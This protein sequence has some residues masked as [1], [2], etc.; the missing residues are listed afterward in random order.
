MLDADD[1]ASIIA[2][3]RLFRVAKAGERPIVFWIGAG[4][5][6]WLGY[7]SWKD[8]ALQVRRAF[9]EDVPGFNDAYAMRLIDKQEFP[10]L[11]QLCKD[12][13]APNYRK[14]IVETFAPR[15]ATPTYN[16]FL[17]LL[18][19]ITPSF[20]LTTNVDECLEKSFPH[21]QTL[22]RSDVTRC[23]DLLNRE[24]PFVAKLHGSIS[25]VQSTVFTTS[26]YSDIIADR[27]YLGCLKHIFTACTVVFLGY[28]V[29]DGYII[30]MLRDNA[31]EMDL[32]GPG[33]HFAVTNQEVPVSSLQ[34][35]KYSPKFRADHTAALSI[36]VHVD[37]SVEERRARPIAITESPESALDVAEETRTPGA[38]PLGKTAYFISDLFA[39]GTWQTSEEI[40]ATNSSNEIEASFGL[41]FTNDEIPIPVST[42]LHD[43]VV[44]LICFDFVYLPF[45]A[46]GSAH[47]VL[48]EWF[49]EFIRL[50]LLR[51]IHNEGK[52][53]VVFKKGEAIGELVIAVGGTTNG[54]EPAPLS[55]LIRRAVH[56]LPG[57]EKEAERLFESLERR[58]SVYRKS[59]E[60][61]FPSLAR[62]ALL[63]PAVSR[64]LGISDLVLP[65]QVP[66]WLRYPYLRLAHLIQTAVLCE[67]YGIQAAKVPFGG[68]QLTNAAFG[69][70][71]IE[72]QADHMAS[73]VSS[74][75]YNSDL[76]ALLYGNMSI[77]RNIIWFRGTPEG[78]AFRRETGEILLRGSGERFNVA[79]NAGLSRAVPRAILQRA[80]DRLLTLMTER[81]HRTRVPAVWGSSL[82]SDGSTRYWRAKSY[83]LL[84]QMC[85]AR[86]IGKNDPCICGSHEKLRLCCLSP[87]KQ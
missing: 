45:S 42:A 51:F 14:L 37:Q 75:A 81:S 43:I 31:R 40:V 4:T 11:F 79:V 84:L 22:Q 36:L 44:G 32:F 71:P 13:N 41:G 33:P 57:K 54:P 87:L 50:D 5:S 82:L 27:S 61:D 86:Q 68:V 70:R 62:S 26:D 72:M 8:L 76:G 3:R 74:G 29:R 77:L 30:E 52:L 24:K 2:A 10:A 28:G 23:I 15:P 21:V 6:R 85:E 53:G 46:L 59:K 55:V 66:R 16:R 78:E 19:K 60:A 73:Y 39:P 38:V 58:T 65:T 9:K 35:I 56:A 25:S 20:V 67:E 48:G 64:L 34:R 49:W 47:E 18:K 17:E 1:P 7:P 69:F 80:Q 12:A 63:M 83:K